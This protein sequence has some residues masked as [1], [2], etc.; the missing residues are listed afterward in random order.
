MTKMW[1]I[2][3]LL[4]LFFFRFFFK[5]ENIGSIL[6]RTEGK[7]GERKTKAVLS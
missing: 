2:Y 5:I 7:I 1:R 4:V 6:L 3:V